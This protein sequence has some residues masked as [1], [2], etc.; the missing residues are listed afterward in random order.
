MRNIFILVLALSTDAFVASI[1]YGANRLSISFIKIIAVNVICSSCLGA[2]LLFGNVIDDLVP[3]MFAKGVGFSCLFLLGVL[4]LLDYTIKKYINNHIHVHKDLTF[5]I[6]GLSII[7]NIYGN[8]MAADWDHSK[9]LSWKETVMFSFAMSIDSLVAGTLSG[10]LMIHPGFA[11]LTALLVG[12]FVM[13]AGLFLG[14][15]LAALKN[16][17]LSWLSG[18]LF[19]FLAFGKL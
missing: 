12:I 17:D 2:A 1:A 18:V 7:I 10:F 3:E 6:S 16:W 15:R 9:T 8:P 14:K 5:S 13:Y 11:A 19:L 4:K